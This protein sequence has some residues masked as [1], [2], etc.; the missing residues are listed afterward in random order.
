MKKRM[1]ELQREMDYER[2]KIGMCK[3]TWSKTYRDDTTEQEAVYSHL[4]GHGSD[5][6]P[7][8]NYYD[9]NVVRY[10]RKCNL[11]GTVEYTK[12]EKAV[13]KSYEP[14]FN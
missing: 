8:Y 3:H 7:I 1:Q 10:A 5:P 4:E 11:C 9:K 2:S 6:H 13:V 12:K 14:D